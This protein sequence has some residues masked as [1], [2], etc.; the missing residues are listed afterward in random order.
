MCIT[1]FLVELRP[2][3]LAKANQLLLLD[4]RKL[5]EPTLADP[6]LHAYGSLVK[7]QLLVSRVA[8]QVED[9]VKS[10]LWMR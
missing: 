9:T 3:R 5:L 2:L 8:P 7:D 6:L 1:E 10:S 4:W